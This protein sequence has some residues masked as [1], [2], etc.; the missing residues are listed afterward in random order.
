MW[1]FKHKYFAD[2]PLSRYKARL[3][4]NGCSQQISVD[5]DET[6]SPVVKPATIRTV[7]SLATS[8][9]WHVHQLDFKNAFLHGM[10]LHER[11]YALEVSKRV[12]MLNCYPCRTPVDIKHKLGA[13]GVNVSDPTL[14][15]SPAGA[16]QYLTF[17]RPDLSFAA[18]GN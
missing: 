3:V 17:T 12:G 7:L 15:R 5:C 10:F 18:Y 8:R 1:L 2:E 13:N 6:F 9:H 14:H 4:V 16:L 11:Q